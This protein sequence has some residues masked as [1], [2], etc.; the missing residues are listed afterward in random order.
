[1]KFI[2][3][4]F[5]KKIEKYFRKIVKMFEVSKDLKKIQ[6]KTKKILNPLNKLKSTVYDIILLNRR[7][8]LE[9]QAIKKYKLV[10]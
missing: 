1:M 7:N 9:K 10:I 3:G 4:E 6:P 5:S 2:S 8:R